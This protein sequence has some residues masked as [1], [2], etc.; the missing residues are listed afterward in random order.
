[1]LDTGE[2]WLFTAG[3]VPVAGDPDILENTANVSGND[4]LQR[5]ATATVNAS[6]TIL[7]PSL[8]V[9]KTLLLPEYIVATM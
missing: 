9:V 5:I 4:V 8:A 1:M 6:V 7:K 2:T 3:Y